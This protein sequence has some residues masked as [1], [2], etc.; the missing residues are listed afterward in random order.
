MKYTSIKPVL[1][2]LLIDSLGRDRTM[3]ST[4][5]TYSSLN[6]F[7]V[8]CALGNSSGRVVTY[9]LTMQNII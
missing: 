1:I 6:S 4:A 7:T 8:E 5:I 3:P 9:E 2:F